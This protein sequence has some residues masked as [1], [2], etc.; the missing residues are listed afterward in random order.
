[1]PQ[2][3]LCELDRDYDVAFYDQ[4]I[5]W[6]GPAAFNVA[7]AIIDC[8]C[9]GRII[10]VGCGPGTYMVQFRLLGVDVF[11]VE[12]SSEGVRRCRAQG[13]PVERMDLTNKIAFNRKFDVAICFEVAE[14]LPRSASDTLVASL[15]GLSSTIVFTA[16]EPGQ[17]GTGHMNEQP[18]SYWDNKF[19]RHSFSSNFEQQEY[20]KS[21]FSKDPLSNP[22]LI[23]N[24][25][26][27]QF[28]SNT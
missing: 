9:P 14:H 24:L 17:G 28:R 22:W 16:A 15:V 12:G 27:Y 4:A 8:F 11:G 13:L 3:T 19:L 26:V 2:K 1:M 6:Q 25:R 10:D 7:T 18:L 20:L 5:R 23:S 21:R